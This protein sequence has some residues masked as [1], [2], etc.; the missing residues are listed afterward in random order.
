VLA[1]DKPAGWMLVPFNWQSTQRNLH[2]AL[3]SSIAAGDF[4]A[5]S[6][7]IK[8]VRHIHRL[9]GDTSGV[10]LLGRSPGAVEAYGQL[11]EERKVEKRYLAVVKGSPDWVR[12]DCRLKIAPDPREP[13]RVRIDVREGKDA[14]TGFEVLERS[15]RY[16][17][18]E[19]RPVTGRTHQIRIHLARLGFPV[20]GDPLYGSE[21]MAGGGRDRGAHPLGL[22]AVSLKYV[23]PFRK[24]E[25][26][27]EASSEGFLREFG[28]QGV[29]SEGKRPSQ[30]VAGSSFGEQTR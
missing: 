22:R 30:P 11:F 18:L 2:A 4:W 27:I 12:T 20:V 26:V 19:A 28:F 10:L 3:V 8:F 6:R 5:R 23:D 17:L 25:V 29:A 21:G 9:D 13:G 7:N 16:S 14:L 15:G 24:C 1:V